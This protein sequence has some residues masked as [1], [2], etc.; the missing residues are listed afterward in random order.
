LSP[1]R[2]NALATP[3]PCARTHPDRTENLDCDEPR[4]RV[5][6]PA[7]EHHVT[8]HLV[9]GFG[10][11]R[12]AALAAR[13]DAKVVDE[14]RHIAAVVAERLTMHLS[15]CTGVVRSLKPDF[16]ALSPYSRHTES[17]RRP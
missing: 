8:H 15:D 12:G 16:H 10:H 4:G 14:R 13:H 7:T 17:C 3:F 9:A 5:E 6:Q 1:S 2:I 11:Q